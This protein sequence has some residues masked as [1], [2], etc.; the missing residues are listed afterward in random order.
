MFPLARSLPNDL[1]GVFCAGA[2]KTEGVRD[3]S[4]PHTTEAL[5]FCWQENELCLGEMAHF[6]S[7]AGALCMAHQETEILTSVDDDNGR[8]KCHLSIFDSSANVSYSNNTPSRNAIILGS[9]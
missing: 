7:D 8:Q 2:V 5:V 9:Q 3:G 1:R 6:K 4:L